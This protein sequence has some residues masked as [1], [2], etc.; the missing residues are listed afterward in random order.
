MTVASRAKPSAQP[1][2]FAEASAART[3][4]SIRRV[5]AAIASLRQRGAQVTLAAIAA[6][7]ARLDPT[8]PPL[9]PSTIIHNPRCHAAYLA[10][11]PPLR[12]SRQRAPRHPTLSRRSKAELI[13]ALLTTRARLRQAQT[14]LRELASVHPGLLT[15][16]SPSECFPP[17]VEA[18]D[19]AVAAV[20]LSPT[21]TP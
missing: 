18:S 4:A 1:A 12:R 14:M 16:A 2:A 17:E 6:E 5:E 13:A 8:R 15:E 10:A 7:S 19:A 9:A 3:A 11:R 21:D 20:E